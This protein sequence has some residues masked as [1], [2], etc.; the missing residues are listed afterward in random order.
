MEQQ[1]IIFC[2]PDKTGKTEIAHELSSRL[3]IP[4]FK[5]CDEKSKFRNEKNFINE[6]RYADPR[7]L[8]LLSQTGYSLILDRAY[9]C[10]WVYSQFFHR[11]TD[12]SAVRNSDRHF[13]SLGTKIIVCFRS[14]YSGLYDEDRPDLLTEEN[15]NKLSKL[16]FEFG[17]WTQCDIY[18]L[19][20]D[21]EDLEQEIDEIT[22]FLKGKK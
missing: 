1:L 17:K 2:G 8:D 21:S 13:A 18:Y 9:P 15:L 22:A 5:A 3:G 16:Y 10:E 19:N 12:L 14:D 20:V 6:M 11:E 4:T 7:M